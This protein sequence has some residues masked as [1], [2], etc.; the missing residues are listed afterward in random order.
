MECFYTYGQCL[1]IGIQW[2]SSQKH[3]LINIMA[4]GN[5]EENVGGVGA[6]HGRIVETRRAMNIIERIKM[7]KNLALT[8][9]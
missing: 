7:Y 1:G 6:N 5:D 9:R 8:A 2:D 3:Y 4:V